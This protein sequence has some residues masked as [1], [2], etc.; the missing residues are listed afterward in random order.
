MVIVED[1]IVCTHHVHLS[2][3]VRPGPE[4]KHTGLLV[5]REVSDVHLAAATVDHRR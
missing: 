2:G 1:S 3:T 4:L 5:K